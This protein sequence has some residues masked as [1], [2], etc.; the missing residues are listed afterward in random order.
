MKQLFFVFLVSFS[1]FAQETKVE[2][3]TITS[4]HAGRVNKILYLN[5][6]EAV[7]MGDDKGLSFWNVKT[8]KLIKKKFL[9]FNSDKVGKINAMAASLNGR[10]LYIGGYTPNANGVF[11][12]YSYDRK[13]DETKEFPC[14]NKP[15]TV[16]EINKTG[17]MLATGSLDSTVNVFSLKDQE[18]SKTNTFTFSGVVYD[19]SFSFS[20]QE[21]AVATGEKKFYINSLQSKKQRVVQK[22]FHPVKAVEYSPDSLFLVTG[23]DDYLVNLYDGSGK[24]IRKLHKSRQAITDL[25]FSDDGRFLIAAT[26]G[27][28]GIDCVSLPNGQ[29]IQRYADFENTVQSVAFTPESGE[30][31]YEVLA[32]GGIHHEVRLLNVLSGKTMKVLGHNGRC[33]QNLVFKDNGNLGFNFNKDDKTLKFEFDMGN[34]VLNKLIPEKFVAD[35]NM[36]TPSLPYQCKVEGRNIVNSEE[37]EGR[38][39]LVLKTSAQGVLI[40]SDFSLK[41]VNLQDG[42]T[43]LLNHHKGAIRA[44]SIDAKKEWVATSG[45]DQVVNFWKMNDSKMNSIPVFSLFVTETGEWVC[46]SPEGYFAGS[47]NADGFIGWQVT[48]DSEVWAKM[49]EV[50]LFSDVLYRPDLLIESYK[51]KKVIKDV[52]LGK[53]ETIIDLSRLERASPPEFQ[54][55]I[56]FARGIKR[57]MPE[58]STDVFLTDTTEALIKVAVQYGG[59]GIAELNLFQNDKLIQIDKD[60]KLQSF[61]QQVVKEYPVRLLPGKNSFKVNTVNNRKMKSAADYL[62]IECTSNLLPVSDLYILT[63]GINE[64]LNPKMNLNYGVPDAQALSKAITENGKGIFA[65]IFSYN[66]F[67]KDATIDKVKEAIDQIKGKAKLSDV[68]VIYYAGHGVVYIPETS[69]EGEFYMVLHDVTSMNDKNLVEKGIPSSTFRSWLSEIN[70]SKQLVLMDACHSEASF[71]SNVTRRGLAEQ[72]AIYQLARSSGSVIIAAC[73]SDQTAKEFKDLGHG[74]FTYALLEALSGKADGGTMDKKITVGEI[75]AYIEDRVPQLTQKYSGTAQYPS[76]YSVGQD[77]PI[78]ISK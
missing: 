65:N 23:G 69:D 59:G 36:F 18:A 38:M 3:T 54:E 61:K 9:K 58:K 70:A 62:T 64:Y 26:L 50:S 52:L 20:N 72:Q 40:G 74:A 76:G 47:Q 5:S 1:V 13:T 29:L 32:T 73:G 35:K 53:K 8:G 31:V 45:E 11:C 43:S 30:G 25:A 55:P 37:N 41:E 71:K 39:L 21:I 75:K 42:K 6:E 77:F 63:I 2:F 60:F 51:S 4:G 7:T 12:F 49:S 68:L 22:H 44:M 57:S 16:I 19:A 34:M 17:T 46:W 66:L 56:V 28:G 27:N 14:H 48:K 78:V 33:V 24:F 10:L 67:N 15:I